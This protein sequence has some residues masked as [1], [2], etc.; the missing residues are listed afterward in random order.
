MIKTI[1]DKGKKKNEPQFIIEKTLCPTTCII[2]KIKNTIFLF[3]P[4]Q[5]I[6]LQYKNVLNKTEE[7]AFKQI[8]INVCNS[9][10]YISW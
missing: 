8:Q 10:M 1:T 6:H 7:N 2:V 4:M 5:F 9:P 3:A